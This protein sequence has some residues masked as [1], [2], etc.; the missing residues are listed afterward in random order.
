MSTL[1]RLDESHLAAV[2][3]RLGDHGEK[4]EPSYDYFNRSLVR[5]A[6][7]AVLRFRQ[8]QYEGSRFLLGRL[9]DNCFACHSRLPVDQTFVVGGLLTGDV[10]TSELTR[11]DI[12]RLQVVTR[13]FDAAI[14]TYEDILLSESL[15]ASEIAVSGVF[16][17]Y[18]RV[19][20]RVEGDYDRVMDNL[21][22]FNARPDVPLYLSGRVN[23]WHEDIK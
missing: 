3:A 2:A 20:L 17:D 21:K 4:P 8:N 9:M 5:D 16:E 11:Q 7:E 12:A 22:K 18:F 23:R 19:A 6:N 14:Q 15:P 1:G 13:Q 10:D